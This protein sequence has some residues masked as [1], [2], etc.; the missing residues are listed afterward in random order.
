MDTDHHRQRS[1]SPDLQQQRASISSLIARLMNH[2]WTGDDPP[3][4]RRAQAED[5][6]DD[7]VELGPDIVAFACGEW[8]R[9]KSKRPTP[10]EI[11]IIAIAEQRERA[12]HSDAPQIS[13]GQRQA[14]RERRAADRQ[15]RHDEMVAEGQAISRK[16][17]QDRGFADLDAYA[18]SKGISYE[19]ACVEVCHSILA[20]SPMGKALGTAAA[21]GVTAREFTPSAEQLRAGREAL[22]LEGPPSGQPPR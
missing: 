15:R 22:G 3:E 9:T 5:W 14:M 1:Y 18:A 16:W 12:A 2:Y 19:E 8:R 4:I 11:R 6:I 20:G 10:A 17:A 7:L 21:L 13:D